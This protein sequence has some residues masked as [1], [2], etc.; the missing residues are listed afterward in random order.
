MAGQLNAL[1][2][3]G[4]DFNDEIQLRR[5]FQTHLTKTDEHEESI[6]I[7]TKAG[8]TV[9]EPQTDPGSLGLTVGAS[10]VQSEVQSLSDKIDTILEIL[11]KSNIL[12]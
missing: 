4:I 2:A 10:Y 12:S 8:Y 7:L 9:N 6:N 5:L 1:Q 3:S 11:R